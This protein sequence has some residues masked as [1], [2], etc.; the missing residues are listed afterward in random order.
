MN[1]KKQPGAWTKYWVVRRQLDTDIFRKIL[2]LDHLLYLLYLVEA[3]WPELPALRT[4][5]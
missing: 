4:S 1:S 2:T 3:Y 5:V